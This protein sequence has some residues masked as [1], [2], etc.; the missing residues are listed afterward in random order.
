MSEPKQLFFGKEEGKLAIAAAKEHDE[1]LYEVIDKRSKTPKALMYVLTFEAM[2]Q[3]LRA[4]M[5]K[6]MWVFKQICWRTNEEEKDG[7]KE[8]QTEGQEDRIQDDP[9]S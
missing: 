5:M 2:V 7:D 4:K 1:T 6:R 3:M 8:R 9:A